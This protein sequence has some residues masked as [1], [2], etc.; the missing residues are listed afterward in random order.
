MGTGGIRG[1]GLTADSLKAGVTVHLQLEAPLATCCPEI[2]M[3]LPTTMVIVPWAKPIRLA[4][5]PPPLRSAAFT[6]E[7]L[8]Q[9]PLALRVRLNFSCLE[10]NQ[11][12]NLTL[13]PAGTCSRL[14]A[15][16]GDVAL[17]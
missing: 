7:L 6:A 5:P 16:P 17:G 9:V 4:E 8:Q 12:S 3:I 15:N 11:Y 2:G 1:H 10:T 13:Y 14:F